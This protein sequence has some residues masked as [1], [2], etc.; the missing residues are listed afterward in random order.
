MEN[1]EERYKEA[2]ERAKVLIDK[3]ESTHIKGFIYH[4]FPELKE[5]EDERIKR[6]IIA[7]I[8]ELADL[9]NEKIPTN[10][11]A[12]LERQGEH[13]PTDKV[14]PLFHGCE[15]ITNGDYTWKIL[16]IKPLDYI[17]QSQDGNIVDDTIS[18][19]DEHFHLWTI[20]DAKDGDVLVNGSNIFIFHFINGTRLMG[21]CH[22]NIDNGRFYDDL[23]KNECFCLIDGIV[24]PATK[25]QRDILERSMTN[26]GYRW[27]V[28]KKE[29]KKIE[30]KSKNLESKTLDADKVIE[31]LK[32]T[33]KERAE[34]YGVYNETRLILP[35]NSIEDLI[36]DFKEDFGL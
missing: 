22:V 15:W 6:E 28:D 18:Y 33:I 10:W 4:I 31:W 24:T 2:L 19:V 30:I 13:K 7:Y 23:G 36:N 14:E 35:Y 21:Y 8:N 3:L 1:Y 12:W 16:G 9:K 17:L 11:L 27:D 26:A 20:Q 25:E 34:N 32:I 29:L 5:S